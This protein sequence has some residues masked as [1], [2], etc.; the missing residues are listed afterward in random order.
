M[1]IKKIEQ[2]KE[3]G[4]KA[5]KSKYLSGLKVKTHIKAGPGPGGGGINDIHGEG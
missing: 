3:E 4:K 2:V 5:A 1:K